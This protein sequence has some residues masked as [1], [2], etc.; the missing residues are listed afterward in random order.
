MGPAFFEEIDQVAS[1]AIRVSKRRI[2]E[3]SGDTDNLDSVLLGKQENRETVVRI[4]TF[5]LSACGIGVDPNSDG[6]S[7]EGLSRM[8]LERFR[9]KFS[10]SP[11]LDGQHQ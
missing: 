7:G 1:R 3:H 10:S 5:T 4:G 8:K 2:A 6:R 11:H 9:G